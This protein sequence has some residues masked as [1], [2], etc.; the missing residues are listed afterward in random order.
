MVE[1]DETIITS[2]KY[3]SAPD[4]T[5]AKGLLEAKTFLKNSVKPSTR[6]QYDKVYQI[7]KNF[8]EEN[9]LP[10]FE[11]GHEAVAACLSNVMR[12]GSLSKVSMLAAATSQL[13]S[14]L[15]LFVYAQEMFGIQSN[16]SLTI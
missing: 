13:L 16:H 9:N 3:M 6:T 11:A 12:E 15:E 4:S 5:L 2:I 14:F 10:E 7:W 8:C 1:L